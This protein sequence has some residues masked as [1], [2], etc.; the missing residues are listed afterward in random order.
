MQRQHHQEL[1][2]TQRDGAKPFSDSQGM[3][4]SSTGTAAAL[5]QFSSEAFAPVKIV[6]RQG[7]QLPERVQDRDAMRF[8]EIEPLPL[9][10]LII[11]V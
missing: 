11:Q 10:D 5:N 1:S 7:R 3:E 4:T 2:F 6:P 9:K 8:F